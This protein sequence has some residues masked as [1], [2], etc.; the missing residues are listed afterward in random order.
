MISEDSHVDFLLL[1]LD[2][3]E[4]ICGISCWDLGDL[5]GAL[6]LSLE[7]ADVCVDVSLEDDNKRFVAYFCVCV[8]LDLFSSQHIAQF[9]FVCG[10]GAEDLCGRAEALEFGFACQLCFLDV[11]FRLI[12]GFGDDDW[13]WWSAI[14]WLWFSLSSRWILLAAAG[15]Y[16]NAR[17]WSLWSLISIAALMSLQQFR[18]RIEMFCGPAWDFFWWVF[19]SFQPELDVAL[20]CCKQLRLDCSDCCTF[21]NSELGIK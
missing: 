18:S 11:E 14:L 13:F 10:A 15:S 2:N 20:A 1:E 16:E 5:L 21:H 7:L 8:E 4:R 9:D 12:E 19:S 17:G 6:D 3:V